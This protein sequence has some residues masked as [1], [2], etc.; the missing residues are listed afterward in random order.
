MRDSS[1]LVK[2]TNSHVN[3]RNVYEGWLRDKVYCGLVLEKG[4]GL[5]GRALQYP[6]DVMR[7]RN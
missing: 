5:G 6:V 1:P 2:A 4:K 3:P 7:V